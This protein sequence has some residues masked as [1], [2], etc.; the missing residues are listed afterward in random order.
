ML[1]GIDFDNTIVSYDALFHK[2]ALEWGSI[3]PDIS[4]NKTSIRNYLRRIDK[5]NIWTEMQGYVYGLRM[6]KEADPFP[7]VQQFF[8]FCHE[9]QIPVK[10]IS[11]KTRYPYLGERYDLHQA[12][13]EWLI[14][15][16]FNDSIG[17][18][19]EYF[20]PEQTKLEKLQRIQLAG[21]THFIDDLPELLNEAAFPVGVQRILFDPASEYPH[22]QGGIRASSWAEIRAL[23]E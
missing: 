4:A 9:N 11:H 20:Y 22:F 14:H 5:E 10:I 2:I 19:P 12:A 13:R 15:H 7:G 17:F 1:I 3:P 23:F 8:T 18:L 6:I 21:C 16:G